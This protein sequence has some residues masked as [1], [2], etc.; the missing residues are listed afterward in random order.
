MKS[1]VFSF[2]I[3]AVLTIATARAQTA[4]TIWVSDFGVKPYS[5]ENS[6]TQIQAA[7]EACRTKGAQ[8]LAFEKGRYDIWPE[9][10][11]RRE[12]YISNTSTHEEC[13]SKVKTIGLLFEQIH[14]LKIIGN[15]ALLMFHGKMTPIA[16]DSCRDITF[17]NLHVDFERPSASELRYEHVSKGM[18]EVAVHQDT[19]Y[20]IVNG[21]M[22]LF[23]EG[24]KSNKNHCIEY[25]RKTETFRY[26]KDWSVLSEAPAQEVAPDIVRFKV[27]QDFHPAQGNTLTIRDII[28][29]QVGMFFRYS[30]NVTLNHIQMHYMHGLGIVC[31]YAENVTMNKVECMPRPE[32]GRLLAASADM[33]HFSGCKGHIRIDSCRFIGAQDD[34]INI[35]GTNLKIIGKVNDRT[36]NLKF[37][38]GQT[39]GFPAYFP[40]DT[41]AFIQASTLQRKGISKVRS[42]TPLTEYVWQ[43]EFTEKVPGWLVPDRDCVENLTYTPSV[44]IRHCY[45]TRI[46]TRGTLV[47]TP[48]KV[49][50]ENNVYYKIGMSAILIE[51]DAKSWFESGPVRDVLIQGN[52]FVDCGY[53]GGPGNAVIAIHPSNNVVDADL[54]VHRNIR[55]ENNAFHLFDYPLLYAKSTKGLR[56]IGN[57]IKRSHTLEPFSSNHYLFYLNGCSDV[58]IR[59]TT[60]IGDILNKDIYSSKSSKISSTTAIF[61]KKN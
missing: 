53:N 47:T 59:N 61:I 1:L 55:I 19:R 50:I 35:H 48:K 10:A 6:V 3:P 58:T 36:L 16:V 37:A 29:D 43:V 44:E 25:D 49:V 45:F 7:I 60:Y 31:Q 42:V 9:G 13:P 17:E 11:E 28:R 57:T 26:S 2:F 21:R 39:Y 32:S 20:E 18:V 34:G 4:D 5:Y 22:L 51:S 8:V 54:P 24:W 38:H 30:R 52:T 40:G 41:V 33:M 14:G 56:F 23:G 27:P 46:N 15:D 12:Y